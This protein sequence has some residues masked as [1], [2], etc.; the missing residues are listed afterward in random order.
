LWELRGE[1]MSFDI[2]KYCYTGNV[3]HQKGKEKIEY[4]H[5][6]I[7]LFLVVNGSCTADSHGTTLQVKKEEVLCC[8]G[9][10]ALYPDGNTEIMGFNINGIIADKYSKEVGTG[11][12]TSGIFAPFL[13]QQ[14]MQI[15]QGYDSL[16]EL[17]ITNISFEILNTLSNGDK[18]A[19]IA[20]QI[21][22]DAV[23]LIKENYANVY[24]VEELAQTLQISKSHLV[25]EFFKHTGTTPGKYLTTVRIDAVKQLLTQTSLPLNTIALQTGFSGDNYLC[26]AFKKVTGETPMAYKNRVISSQYLPNQLTLTI[27]P[28]VYTG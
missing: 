23:R 28:D 5:S 2:K 20:S 24:G 21:I 9:E 4:N 13:P 26:K 11:F 27:D 19:V 22:V 15:V 6:G 10:I 14:I 16:S 3:I 17:Y 7:N 8:G 1:K 25:R 12:V 18:K